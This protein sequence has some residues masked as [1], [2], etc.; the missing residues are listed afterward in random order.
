M[1]PAD[2]E[3]APRVRDERRREIHLGDLARA[4]S[5]LDCREP[6][7]AAAIAACL[8]FGL[9]P[10]SAADTAASRQPHL[11]S[12]SAVDAAAPSERRGAPAEPPALPQPPRRPQLPEGTRACTL[13]E[14]A[15]L[16]PP[17]AEPPAWLAGPANPF[18]QAP[19]PVVARARLLPEPGARHVLSAA[20]ATRRR[21]GT[22]DLPRLIEAIVRRR[23]LPELPRQ[24]EPTVA[25]GCQLLLDYS[26][27]MVPF[28]PD[29]HDLDEQVRDVLGRHAVTTFGFDGDPL[30]AE[31]W[32][33]AGAPAP[34]TP[35]GRPVLAA[36]DLGLQSPSAAAPRDGWEAFAADCARTGSP[37]LLL[38]PL[39]LDHRARRLPANVTLI[40]WSPRTT[41]GLVR[42][43][44]ADARPR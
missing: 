18:S 26:G 13:T 21:G 12:G 23:V 39:P 2:P 19:E 31:H 34:W 5:R 32:G 40:H 22:A 1:S 20:L 35:D 11:V 43:R 15:D 10:P 33:A 17:D 7:Q 36:S 3:Q 42:R 9:R 37:L 29:L 41:A 44:G 38:T 24:A 30:T 25:A 8:G 4:L 28:W 14:L 6:R 16:A 27:S